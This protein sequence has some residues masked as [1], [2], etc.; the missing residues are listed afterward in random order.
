[1]INTILSSLVADVEK[2]LTEVWPILKVDS[3][4]TKSIDTFLIDFGMQK[5]REGGNM[6]LAPLDGKKAEES[7]TIRDEKVAQKAK[8][9]TNLGGI[10]VFYSNYALFEVGTKVDQ[11]N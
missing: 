9:I 1:M 7:I 11:K 8:L 10:P 5:A 4:K 3:R 6:L 2:D